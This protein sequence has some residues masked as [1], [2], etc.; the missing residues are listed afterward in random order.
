M[1]KSPLG[2]VQREHAAEFFEKHLCRNVLTAWLI[3]PRLIGALTS[4]QKRA[5][6]ALPRSASFPAVSWTDAM[7]TRW[8]LL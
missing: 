4:V 7:E 2:I 3:R 1:N 6:S 5:N 8:E